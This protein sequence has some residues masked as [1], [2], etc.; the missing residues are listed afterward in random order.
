MDSPSKHPIISAFPDIKVN[1][2][3]ISKFVVFLAKLLARLYLFIFL[4]V[5]RTVLQGEKHLFK[6]FERSLSGKSRCIIAFRHPNGGEPQLLSWFFLF[7]LRRLASRAGV[8]FAR[9]PHAVFVYGYEVVRW[10]GWVARFVMPNMGAMPIHHSKMDSKGMA[11]IFR[12]ITNGP[13]PVALAPEGQVSYT[14]DAVP[15]LEP[16]VIRIGFQAAKQLAAKGSECPLE[17]LPIAVHFRFGSWGSFTLEF[18]LK[19]IERACGLSGKGR[20]KMPFTERVK[21]CRTHVLEVI[22]KRYQ[23][24]AETSA[25][26]EKRLDRVI[27]TA[28]ETAER[29]LGEKSEGDFFARMYRMRQICWDRIY[30]PGVDNFEGMSEVQRSAADLNAGEAWY[31]ARHVELVD[32]CWY[33]RIPLPAEGTVIHKKVEYVQNLWDFASRSM[34]GAF[35][36]R[37]NIFPRKVIIHT[38]PSINLSERLPAYSKDKKAEISL[39]M[40]DL[41]RAFLDCIAEAN[42]IADGRQR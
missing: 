15:R 32:F 16:G 36:N 31:I 22:E 41:E 20:K 25:S 12:A 28:L 30:I 1:E 26:F 38:A 8:R 29:M 40:S 39:A 7:K 5:A 33:F 4:G 9:W 2:P 37:V 42:G 11:R 3:R 17:I 24:T 10:G 23:I 34:G 19:K 14:T 18:L 13:Y 21:Q 27:T 35:W 6:A